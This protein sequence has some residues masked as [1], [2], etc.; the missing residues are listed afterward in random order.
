VWFAAAM[1][2]GQLISKLLYSTCSFQH[3]IDGVQL[4]VTW[5]VQDLCIHL[6]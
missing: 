1:S 2:G 3:S 4:A 6:Y 5:R